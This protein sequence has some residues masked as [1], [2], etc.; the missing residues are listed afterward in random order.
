[1]NQS[2]EEIQKLF[3]DHKIIESESKSWYVG[4]PGTTKNS[5]SITWSPGSMVLYGEQGNVTMI[6]KEFSSYENAKK[7]LAECSLDEFTSTIAHEAPDNLTYF[8]EAC[9][10]WGRE[11][12]YK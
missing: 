6:A 7:W 3:Q 11:P 2:Q 9:Q 4:K 12:H 8:F 10:L 5:F 1:M